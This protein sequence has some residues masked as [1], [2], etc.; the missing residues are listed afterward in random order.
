[1]PSATSPGTSAGSIG[2]TRAL[3][4]PSFLVLAITHAAARLNGRRAI[5]D[6]AT[7]PTD[8]GYG[9]R[10]GEISAVQAARVR[11]PARTLPDRRRN[12][13]RD[14]LRRLPSAARG[15]DAEIGRAHVGT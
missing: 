1:M 7:P 9:D 14:Q 15:L 10:R 11:R 2:N 5:R 13:H 12:Q 3:S 8:L 6:N 4:K